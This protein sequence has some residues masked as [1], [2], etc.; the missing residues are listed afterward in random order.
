M[1]DMLT[2]F[3]RREDCCGCTACRSICPTNAISMET[4]AEGFL[5][6]R[7]DAYL[8]IDCG[9]CRQTCAFQK[10][11]DSSSNFQ[12]P[13][14][15]AVKHSSDEVR[16]RSS[17][18]GFFTAI[19]DHV[20]NMGGL[21]YGA[22]FTDGFRVIHRRVRTIEGRD[23]LRGSK[24]VQSEM[25]HCFL[26]VKHDLEERLFVMFTGTPCQCAS[27]RRYLET[28]EVETLSLITLDIICYGT[29]SY[30]PFKDFI[31]F[32]EEEEGCKVCEFKFRSKEKGWGST[33]TVVYE[34][35]R[36]DFI[37]R[38][39]QLYKKLFFSN[40]CL[41]PCCHEC[42]YTNLKRASEITMADF[43][44]IEDTLPEFKDDLGVSVVL[45]NNAKGRELFGKLQDC[46]ISVE[47]SLQACLSKQSA[48]KTPAAKRPER[49]EFWKDYAAYGFRHALDRYIRI[50]E[51]EAKESK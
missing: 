3:D 40:L 20:L 19:S 12:S 33:E 26:D 24:Y 47:S 13:Y 28:A 6:P 37:S 4:D 22:A 9:L 27:L 38:R 16:A 8:C 36:G 44:G 7:I 50:D 14:V 17:S 11:Y 32:L 23:L 1:V 35:G 29:P 51:R 21:V 25:E 34:D 30:K 41:R 45:L 46:L 43:W 42:R 15:F 10:G 5:Y 39:S 48:L 31:A 18:G 49:Q 2:V